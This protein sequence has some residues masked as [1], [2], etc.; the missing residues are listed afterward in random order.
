MS[1]PFLGPISSPLKIRASQAI[2]LRYFSQYWT[3][4]RHCQGM[5]EILQ[6]PSTWPTYSMSAKW[7]IPMLFQRKATGLSN[8]VL[9]FLLNVI[10]QRGLLIKSGS[11]RLDCYEDYY[12]QSTWTYFEN[13]T[14]LCHWFTYLTHLEWGTTIQCTLPRYLIYYKE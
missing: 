4:V 7:S 5:H 3:E 12:S 10:I 13:A 6:N 11:L 14:V 2:R 9:F 8:S 1:S